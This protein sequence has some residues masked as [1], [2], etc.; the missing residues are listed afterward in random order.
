[1]DARGFRKAASVLSREHGIRLLRYLSS[2]EWHI[3]SEVS[4]ALDIHTSTVSNLLV[5]MYELGILQRRLR[6]SH[7]RST[8]EYRMLSPR[9]ALELDFQSP[10][11]LDKEAVAYCV[12][13]VANVFAKVE[14]LG[15][16]GIL[17]RLEAHLGTT[18]PDLDKDLSER[19][20]R[21]GAGPVR[22]TFGEILGALHAIIADSIG[23]AAANRVFD[24][25]AEEARRG[26]EDVVHRHNLLYRAGGVF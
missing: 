26:H 15:L 10:P 17:E 18:Q 19:L 12:A 23:R 16:P 24:T 22:K 8:F 13:C 14:R 2:G 21:K 1:M 5:P 4:R 25:A 6:T 11:D 7:V 3:A 20:L 9:V